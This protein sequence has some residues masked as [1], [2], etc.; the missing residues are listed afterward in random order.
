LF[1][2]KDIP[3]MKQSVAKSWIELG[4]F[5]AYHLRSNQPHQLDYFEYL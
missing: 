5:V 3:P 2:E 1:K 4:M